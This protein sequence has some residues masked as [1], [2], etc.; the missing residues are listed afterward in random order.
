MC[1]WPDV[2]YV[3]SRDGIEKQCRLA[4]D[5]LISIL[6]HSDDIDGVKMAFAHNHV[7]EKD[8]DYLLKTLIIKE[9]LDKNYTKK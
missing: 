3:N 1:C 7:Q 8:E 9:K 5:T 6:E 4:P 2:C